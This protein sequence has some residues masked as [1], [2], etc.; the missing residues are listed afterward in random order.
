M[1]NPLPKAVTYIKIYFIGLP[2]MLLYNFSAA[3]LRGVGDTKRPLYILSISGLANVLLNL[4][5][6][7]IF[8]SILLYLTSLF[9]IKHLIKIR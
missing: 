4:F 8:S 7:N 1:S 6:Q 5:F 9:F 2:F 3:I